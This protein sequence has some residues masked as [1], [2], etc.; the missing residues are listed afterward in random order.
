[1]GNIVTIAEPQAMAACDMATKPQAIAWH[2]S[3]NKS[4]WRRF[5][6][7]HIFDGEYRD[8]ISFTKTPK[9]SK[10]VILLSTGPERMQ[11]LE[12]MLSGKH[13]NIILR[14]VKTVPVRIL[15]YFNPQ[16][17]KKKSNRTLN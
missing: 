15:Q 10:L 2:I 13:K 11:I 3:K 6:A 5:I 16:S 8:C 7:D 4:L 17:T 9:C 12:K 1:M 14:L